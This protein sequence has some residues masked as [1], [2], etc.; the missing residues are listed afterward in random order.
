MIRAV[1]QSP[2]KIKEFY[3]GSQQAEMPSTIF[4]INTS[5]KIHLERAMC[6]LTTLKIDNEFLWNA[7]QE[8]LDKNIQVIADLLR[9]IRGTQHFSMSCSFLKGHRQSLI[10]RAIKESGWL[11]LKTIEFGDMEFEADDLIALLGSFKRSLRTLNLRNVALGG[12]QCWEDVTNVVGR[13]LDFE[14]L[15]LF[16]VFWYDIPE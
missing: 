1:A 5:D 11:D 6:H 9:D 8:T 10:A 3:F 14:K 2:L 16:G 15:T 7:K 4:H 12:D 13:V